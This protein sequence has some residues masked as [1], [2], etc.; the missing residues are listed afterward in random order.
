MKSFGISVWTRPSSNAIEAV[1]NL[2]VEPGSY[3]SETALFFHVFCRAV[4]LSS[5]ERVSQL[6]YKE[7]VYGSKGVFKL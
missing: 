6:P 1:T 5:E 2:N 7:S 3:P 4:T